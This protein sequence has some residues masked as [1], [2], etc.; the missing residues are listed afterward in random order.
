MTEIYS[1]SFDPTSTYF[2]LTS[3]RGTLHVFRLGKAKG[4]VVVKQQDP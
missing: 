2:G 4:T 3:V 1:M